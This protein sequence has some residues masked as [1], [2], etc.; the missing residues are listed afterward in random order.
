MTTIGGVLILGLINTKNYVI[1]RSTSMNIGCLDQTVF[2][3]Q[4][5]RPTL[6]MRSV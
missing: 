5:V 2:L 4:P 3:F 1:Y 6:K